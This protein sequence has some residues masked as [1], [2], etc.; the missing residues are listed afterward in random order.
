VLQNIL[1]SVVASLPTTTVVF[2]SMS[3]TTVEVASSLAKEGTCS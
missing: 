1:V 2:C 3:A